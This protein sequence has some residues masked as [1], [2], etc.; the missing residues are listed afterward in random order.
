MLNVEEKNK[1]EQNNQPWGVTMRG[2]LT[3]SWTSFGLIS[4][5][6]KSR[7]ATT[8]NKN[9]SVHYNIVRLLFGANSKHDSFKHYSVLMGCKRTVESNR[10]S[11]FVGIFLRYWLLS[12]SG[13]GM[14]VKIFQSMSGKGWESSKVTQATSSW[15]SKAGRNPTLYTWNHTALKHAY[16]TR[17][18][19]YSREKPTRLGG[20]FGEEQL[21]TI[22]SFS[23]FSR[24]QFPTSDS[25][26]KEHH[27]TLNTNLCIKWPTYE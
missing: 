15:E 22:R 11:A 21:T 23:M 14:K 27:Q 8:R 3:P 17:K 13:G 26:G 7:P 1:M 9:H 10:I 2:S 25:K 5:A 16:N 19:L 18:L 20:Q 24:D 6:S 4:K 12:S